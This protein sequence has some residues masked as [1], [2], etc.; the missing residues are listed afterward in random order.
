MFSKQDEL[1]LT[2]RYPDLKPASEK[3]EGRIDLKAA[4]NKKTRQFQIIYPGDSNVIDG[5]ELS[6]SF[7]IA[8]QARTGCEPPRIPA[9]KV[10]GYPHNKD[11]HID[12]DGVA[13][14]CSP[15]VEAEYL[16]PELDGRRFIEELVVPFLWPTVLRASQ[17]LALG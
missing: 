10:E 1:F 16:A 6:G 9:L 5:Y 2:N 11:R 12:H 15:F 3:I 7:T 8:M 13:C 14:L 4:F 17:S